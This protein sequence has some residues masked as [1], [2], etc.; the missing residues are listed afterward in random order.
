MH[1]GVQ[2]VIIMGNAIQITCIVGMSIWRVL[3]VGVK[4]VLEF[5]KAAVP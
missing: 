3:R 2:L 5:L 4:S 1:A